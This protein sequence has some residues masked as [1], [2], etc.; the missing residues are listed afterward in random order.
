[1]PLAHRPATQVQM[2][3]VCGS[4]RWK[5]WE[6]LSLDVGGLCDV[7]RKDR[8]EKVVDFATGI[9]KRNPRLDQQE[10][11]S[12]R[13]AGLAAM[14][15]ENVGGVHPTDGALD[16]NR[17]G[18]EARLRLLFLI[19]RLSP[20]LGNKPHEQQPNYYPEYR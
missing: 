10:C 3:F 12:G 4:W 19:F 15:F 17:G 1:M 5:W 8:L 16:C 7:W 20:A 11:F 13:N 14:L 2:P 18:E 6:S 9:G